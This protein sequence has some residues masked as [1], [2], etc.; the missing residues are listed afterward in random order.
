[1]GFATRLLTSGVV[2]QALAAVNAFG[3]VVDPKTGKIIAGTRSSQE[4]TQFVGTAEQ[5]FQGKACQAFGGLSTTLVVIMMNA[6]LGQVE[7]TK[8]AQMAQDGMARAIRPVHTQ[9]DGDMVFA[10][11][12]G[13]KR[14]DLNTLGTAAAEVTTEAILRAVK[15]ARGMGG[16]PSWSELVGATP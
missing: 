4:G 3:D 12:V 9:F 5:M 1:V 16:V 10:L 2:V 13:Q 7:T 14:A 11:S 15:T 6:A 8:V